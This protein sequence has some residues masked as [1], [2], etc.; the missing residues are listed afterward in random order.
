[1]TTIGDEIKALEDLEAKATARPWTA[2][3]GSRPD[4]SIVFPSRGGNV[5]ARTTDANAALI[6]AAVNALPRLLARLREA[7][8]ERDALRKAAKP[9]AICHA[10]T[11]CF[12]LSGFPR[13]GYVCPGCRLL[14]A[15]RTGGGHE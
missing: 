11:R 15:L 14:A 3:V 4:D 12:G 9:A 13:G 6:V 10:P 5:I 8:G 1:M 7:E 2:H